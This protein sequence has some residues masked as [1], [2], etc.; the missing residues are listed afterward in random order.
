M[1]DDFEVKVRSRAVGAVLLGYWEI[2][3]LGR[4]KPVM[5]ARKGLKSP[6]MAQMAGQQALK[7]L[8][9]QTVH[10]VAPRIRRGGPY[11]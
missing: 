1:S 2:Y 10:Q 5:R 11:W 4:F 9:D 8:F 3:R 7:Q 6:N